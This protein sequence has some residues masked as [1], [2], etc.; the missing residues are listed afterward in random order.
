MR[1]AFLLLLLANLVLLAWR[2]GAFGPVA[3]EGREP[4]RLARQIAPEQIRVLSADQVAVLRSP[5]P[6]ARDGNGKLACVELGDFDEAAL[7]RIQPRLAA[8]ALG[9]RLRARRVD[10]P[11][12]FIVYLPPAAT[13][14]EA[15]RLAQDLRGRGFRDLRVM[16][17]ATQMPNAIVLGSFRDQELAQRHQAD[18]T[19]RGLQGAQV[20]ERASGSEATRFEIRGVDPALA[21]QLAEIQK[22]FPQSQLGTCT[23]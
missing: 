7:A 14:A 15:E 1:L 6:V 9:D 4:Q 16:G 19:R 5:E 12:W 22:E 2:Q 20:T 23:N 11:G 13:R 8:L 21:Q 10:A 3:E 17:P 18:L